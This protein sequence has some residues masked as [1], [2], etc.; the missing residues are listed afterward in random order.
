[1]RRFGRRRAAGIGGLLALVIVLPFAVSGSLG[2]WDEVEVVNRQVGALDCGANTSFASTAWGRVVSGALGGSSL[3]G[4]AA[5]KGLTVTNTAPATSSVATGAS[6]SHDATND[7]W[8]SALDLSALSAVDI[9][10]GVHLPFGAGTGVYTQYGRATAAGR[11]TGASGAVT[12]AANGLVSLDAPTGGTPTL[13]S[14]MLSSVLSTVISDQ[15]GANA[16]RLADVGLSIGAVGST[17]DLDACGA[18]WAAQGDQSAYVTRDYLVSSLG[19]GLKSSILTAVQAALT[20]TLTTTESTLDGLLAPGTSI[21]GTTLTGLTSVLNPLLNLTVLGIPLTGGGISSLKVGVDFDLQPVKDLLAQ[22]LTSG[23]VVVNLASGTI[24]ADLAGANG[25][26][27]L[28]SLPANS[29]LLT[30]ATVTKLTQDVSNAITGLVTGTLTTALTSAVYGAAVTVDIAASQKAVGLTLVNLAIK[31]TGTLGAFVG[32]SGYGTV[33]ATVTPT[34]LPV[35][36]TVLGLLG[37]G[38]LDPSA[39]AAGITAGLVTPLVQNFVPA[40]AAAVLNPVVTGATS[41][42]T[43]T[44]ST[45]TNTTLPPLLA[46]LNPVFTLLQRLVNVTANAQPD[47]PNPVGVPD[48]TAPGTYFV[49]ALKIGAVNPDTSAS[50]LGL[51]LGSS[52]V[53]PNGRR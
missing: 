6:P 52:S 35:L 27:D 20:S 29:S 1:M 39:I 5:L 25:L 19:L 46:Q 4:V 45:V 48:P 9:G 8:T 21:T 49:S 33:T 2:A 44:L 7:A 3:D 32:Q 31:L 53:G 10:A 22:D 14:L 41:T 30:P 28:N 13:G 47:R 34:V 38:A 17:A 43:T 16:S 40:L 15:L 26:V 18:A 37:L 36:G 24:M 50:L 51:Y 11:S 12:S 23:S 42:V